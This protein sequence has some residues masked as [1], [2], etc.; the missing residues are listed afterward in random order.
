[1]SAVTTEKIA[2]LPREGYKLISNRYL[3]Y[4]LMTVAFLVV[5]WWVARNSLWGDVDH[6]WVNINDIIVEGKMPYR[7]SVFEYPPLTLIVFLIPRLLSP[8]IEVFHYVFAVY[9]LSA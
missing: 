9:A 8:S 5:L 2:I 7:E 4:L 1:M 6:Y 3:C